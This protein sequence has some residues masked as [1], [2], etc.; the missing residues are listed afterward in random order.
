MLDAIDAAAR[1]LRAEGGCFTARNLYWALRRAGHDPGSLDALRR[2]PLAARL[3]R[4]PLGGLLGDERWDGAPLAR[5]Y[6]AYFPQAVL[7]VDRPGVLGLFVASGALS[8]AK[9]A[10][11][12]LDGSPRHVVRWLAR[13]FRA[14]HRAPVGFLHDSATVVYPFLVEPLASLVNA[15]GDAERLRYRDLGLPPRGLRA[16]RFPFSE[17]LGADEPVVELEALPPRALVAYATRAM[18]A[19]VPGDPRMA[20]IRR[21]RAPLAGRRTP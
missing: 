11:V 1:A 6:E 12:C 8:T 16:G 15:V 3:E 14:G 5:E 21:A 4:G 7:L 13:G 19:M 17:E 2:G 20:P 10:V 18:L 9:L